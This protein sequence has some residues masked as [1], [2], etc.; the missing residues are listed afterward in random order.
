MK[1]IRN[2]IILSI[3]LLLIVIITGMAVTFNTIIKDVH[4]NLIKREM[5][6]KID[7]I[8]I[9]IKDHPGL[10]TGKINSSFSGRILDFS[11]L[12]SLRIT[13]VDYNGIVIADSESD[14]RSMDNHRYRIEIQK[15]IENQQGESIRYSNT[16]KV[17]MLYAA[18][19]FDNYVIRLAKPLHE[20]D[21]TQRRFTK[22][23]FG[24]G[25]FVIVLALIILIIISNKLTNPIREVRNFALALTDGDYSKRMLNFTND[26]IGVLQRTLNKMADQI[27]Q[28]MNLLITEQNKLKVTFES[29]SDGIAVIDVNKRIVMANKA[30][31]SLMDINV[32]TAA[33]KIYYEAIRSSLLN[34]NIESSIKTGEASDFQEKLLTEKFCEIFIIPIREKS[35]LMGILL[36]LHDITEKKKID[37]LKTDLIGNLSHELKT[38]IAILKG[39]LETIQLSPEDAETNTEYIAK[40][41]VN[42]ERQNSIINDMLKLNMLET[43]TEMAFEKINLKDIISNC[44]EI[45]GTKAKAK[46]IE[47]NQ[48]IDALNR[49]FDGNKFLAEEIFFNIILNAIN[50]NNQNGSI[51]IAAEEKNGMV[52]VSISDTGIGIPGDS[53]DRIFERFYRVDRSRSRVTGGTG[54]GLSI[55]KHAAEILGWKIRVESGKSGT[56]FFIII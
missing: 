30:F 14:P 17:D 53:I 42:L 8:N 33:G 38:P 11:K 10:F 36:V 31:A 5:T 23:I 41:L 6:E 52:T 39:Y 46:S 29:I 18:K 2:K 12:I 55:V 7:F 20:I 51:S 16:I 1:K 35:A 44:I 15:A 49:Q 19:R 48:S 26:E 45:L 24:S 28:E 13:I 37:Q 3:T 4:L 40:A 50:Y 54:L 34:K 9:L 21:E 47:I 25:L 43:M 32:E 56:T 27:V 22:I